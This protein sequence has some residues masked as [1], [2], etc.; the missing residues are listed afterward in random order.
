MESSVAVAVQNIR[1]PSYIDMLTKARC[2]SRCGTFQIRFSESSSDCDPVKR[3][4][5]HITHHTSNGHASYS[6]KAVCDAISCNVPAT[7]K[8]IISSDC[9]P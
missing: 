9:N 7:C 3:T 2:L 1:S 4:D 8:R 5:L 6:K